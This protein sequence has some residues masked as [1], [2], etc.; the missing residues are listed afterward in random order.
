VVVVANQQSATSLELANYYLE[1]RQVPPQNLVRISWAGGNVQW[2]WSEFEEHLL[3]PLTNWIAARG[4]SNQVEIIVLST[5]IP[6]RIHRQGDVE[7][8]G[9]NSTTSALFY[10]F[11]SDGP[12]E[13]PGLPASCNLPASASNS[14]FA[15]E[16]PFAKVRGGAF[17]ATMITSSNL[18]Q[19]K[20]T[21]DVGAAS[22]SSFPLQPAYL[23]KSSDRL[24]NIRYWTFDDAVIDTLLLGY[25]TLVRTNTDLLDILQPASGYSGGLAA[26]IASSGLFVPGAMADQLTSYGGY[27]SSQTIKPLFWH[28]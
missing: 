27:C 5:D 24:R 16:L 9:Q 6:Y 15:S 25:P 1:R 17:L 2:S 13:Y 28:F 3:A 11:K 26:F 18:A 4:L 10:G 19:A 8:A 22:D 23:A 21:V 14:Y 20:Q 12:V 7:V